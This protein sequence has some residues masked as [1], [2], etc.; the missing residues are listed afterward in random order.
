MDPNRPHSRF[1][2]WKDLTVPEAKIFFCYLFKMSVIKLPD[3]QSYWSRDPLSKIPFFH[4]YMSKNRFLLILS[5]MHFN[6]D[7]YWREVE[8]ERSGAYRDKLY[9]IRPLVTKLSKNFLKYRPQRELALDE[10]GC[11]Y[12]GRLG[13][14]TYNPAKPNKYSIKTYQ[15]A[16]SRSGYTL[17]FQIYTGKD[18]E[19][20]TGVTVKV[21]LEVL[22]N[23]KV[24]DQGYH[25]YMDNYYNSVEL[26]DALLERDTYACGTVSVAR[27]GVPEVLKFAKSKKKGQG[28]REKKHKGDCVWRRREDC[29]ILVWMDKKPV[30]VIS[31]IH[32]ARLRFVKKNFQGKEILKPEPIAEYNKY[33]FGVD[34]TDQLCT[35]YSLL[36]KH[37]K[38]WR[39]LAM[40]LINIA[41][42]N[43]YVLSHKYIDPKMKHGQFVDALIRS[44]LTESIPFVTLPVQITP[45][46]VSGN[47][48]LSGRH[49]LVPNE[50]T[51]GRKQKTPSRNCIFCKLGG[52]KPRRSSRYHCVR[53]K[54]VLHHGSC[55]E[56]YH[57]LKDLTRHNVE[58]WIQ[59]DVDK[60][61]L[62]ADPDGTDENLG[63]EPMQ[64]DSQSSS[65]PQTDSQSSSN[66]QSDSQSDSQSSL[67]PQSDSQSDSQ[68]SLNTEHVM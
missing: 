16:E 52:V 9:K 56:G 62:A 18:V 51:P 61:L 1:R 28:M 23:A 20:K 37:I 11:P 35:Y 38:W 57:S 60:D 14:R 44:L 32:A 25:V 33:M 49:Y 58:K 47:V 24:L 55:S 31:T 59:G 4:Q 45:Q 65:N 19:Q 34:L 15:L 8:S 6:D 10:G 7:K 22:E 63:V 67:N 30:S 3:L 26:V 21:V 39:K 40:H 27:K 46:K 17:G 53:C 42:V 12:K 66:P 54:V 43:A 64:S 13:F 29:L 50:P 48:R 5:M 41:V 68:S 2:R 36:R